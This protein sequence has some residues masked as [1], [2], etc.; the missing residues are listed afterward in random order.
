MSYIKN[1][2]FD[3]INEE[4]TTDDSD[5]QYEQYLGANKFEI[6]VHSQD[7]SLIACHL[8]SK[9]E[10]ANSCEDSYIDNPGFKGCV[11]IFYKSKLTS[12]R[13]K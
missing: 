12:S 5:Y 8:F 9:R 13:V 7:N 3:K 6:R 11:K 1:Y 2:Y 4:D 10:D